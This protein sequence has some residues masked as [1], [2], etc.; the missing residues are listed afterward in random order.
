M[1]GPS[2]SQRES[3]TDIV[4]RF[5]GLAVE[6][7]ILHFQS[8][9]YELIASLDQLKTAIILLTVAV[10]LVVM[11]FVIGLIAL[12]LGL[13]ALT[14]IPAWVMGVICLVIFLAIAGLLAWLG[15]RRL[16]SITFVPEKTIASLT[17]E[18]EWLQKSISRS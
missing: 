18:L 10:A 6:L 4:R 11:A 13:A 8:A 7:A 12:V 3:L 2:G 9:K 14:G 17:E 16:S 5:A 1:T 15:I